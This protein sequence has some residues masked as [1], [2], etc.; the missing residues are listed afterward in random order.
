VAADVVDAAVWAARHGWAVFPLLRGKK[1]PGVADW[2]N[3]ASADPAHVAA[4]WPR[5]SLGFGVAAGPSGLFVVDCDV[6]K[7]DTPPPPAEGLRNGREALTWLAEQ[8]GETVPETFTVATPSGGTHL[9]FLAPPDVQLRNTAF[10]NGE[11]ALTWCVDTRGGGGYVVGPGSIADGQRYRTVCPVPPVL[12]PGWILRTLLE[13]RA[14]SQGGGVERS[15]SPAAAALPVDG[16]VVGEQW[17]TAALRGELERI[18]AHPATQ[19]GRNHLLN[20]VAYTLGR[21]VGAGLLD[22]TATTL[23]LMAATSTWWGVGKPPFTR[24]E[25]LDT[26]KSGLDAG[27]RNPR[28]PSPSQARM[29]RP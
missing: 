23:E 28:T 6:P 22:R 9:Y 10:G 1:R 7:P 25:A 5:W 13:R 26:I 4:N 18:T 17:V 2:E 8:C 16:Q 3:V 12:L 14:A 21:L 27:E 19:S 29:R 11:T 20:S 24:R 15:S